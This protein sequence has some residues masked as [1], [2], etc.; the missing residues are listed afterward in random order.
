MSNKLDTIRRILLGSLYK[1]CK[2]GLGVTEEQLQARL[3]SLKSDKCIGDCSIDTFINMCNFKVKEVPSCYVDNEI[4]ERECIEKSW[5]KSKG[6]EKVAY[7][8]YERFKAFQTDTDEDE[9]EDEHEGEECVICMEYYYEDTKEEPMKLTC[10][11]MIHRECLKEAIKAYGKVACPLCNQEI[12]FKDINVMDK[13]K[14]KWRNYIQLQNAGLRAEGEEELF[15]ED[16]YP[17]ED[18]VQ[19]S[20]PKPN[21][22]NFDSE[23]EYKKKY[24]E[25]EKKMR[26]MPTDEEKTQY[27]LILVDKRRL[28]EYIKNNDYDNV[29]RMLEAGAVPTIMDLDNIIHN[30]ERDEEP[31]SAKIMDLIFSYIKPEDLGN[32]EYILSNN[33]KDVELFFKYV[34]SNNIPED[35]ELL[36][37]I[38]HNGVEAK[39]VKELLDKGVKPSHLSLKMFAIKLESYFN[40]LE[41]FKRIYNEVDY[42]EEFK[43]VSEK[44]RKKKIYQAKSLIIEIIFNLMD[45]EEDDGK[46][47]TIKGK[48]KPFIEFL[49]NDIGAENLARSVLI[50]YY[51]EYNIDNIYD[52]VPLAVSPS[53]TVSILYKT[54]NNKD[55]STK[56]LIDIANKV[57]DLTVEDVFIDIL[58]E[59]IVQGSSLNDEQKEFIRLILEKG[60]KDQYLGENFFSFLLTVGGDQ[61][62][63]RYVFEI[64]SEGIYKNS[65]E[66]FLK[67]V[68]KLVKDEEPPGREELK[69]SLE[70]F[71]E[72][73]IIDSLSRDSRRYIDILKAYIEGEDIQYEEQEDEDEDDEYESEEEN[74][75]DYN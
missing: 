5:K 37:I 10:G 3:D 71:E 28:R 7:D 11:H 17:F 38:L 60:P 41:L 59:Y 39:Y 6:I 32:M 24:E 35:V 8:E 57:R 50:R 74:D 64:M 20:N 67:Y 43:I 75:D 18:W 49:V 21:R 46:K 44:A 27:T 68:N 22:E 31:I 12:E 65:F 69:L 72:L 47:R 58:P 9:K 66:S 73:I 13:L 34:R 42:E 54:M 30:R 14:G 26:T 36:D 70:L 2:E 23:E 53:W 48:S 55:I 63:K 29:K 1:Q 61:K 45:D 4:E 16:N 51:I 40:E 19:L 62:V 25:Y 33:K 52:L 15:N 56:F